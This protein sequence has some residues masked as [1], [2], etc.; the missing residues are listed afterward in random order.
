MLK[1]SELVRGY[2]ENYDK[3]GSCF[4][5][6]PYGTKFENVRHLRQNK[7]MGCWNL[8]SRLLRNIELYSGWHQEFWQEQQRDELCGF[9]CHTLLIPPTISSKARSQRRSREIMFVK[10]FNNKVEVWVKLICGCR[11]TKPP[12]YW[13]F[14]F[15]LD[16]VYAAFENSNPI[17]G[18][19]T[20]KKFL[21]WRTP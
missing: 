18:R 13:R 2:V 16:Y 6:T 7:N 5:Y 14:S 4:I 3:S 19:R 11:H 8:L 21:P 9:V 17:E 1:I 12:K 20:F 15:I 10:V